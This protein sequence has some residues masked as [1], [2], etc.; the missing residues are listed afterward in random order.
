MERLSW[1]SQ[2]KRVRN[3]G[4]PRALVFGLILC[5]GVVPGFAAKFSVTLDRDTVVLGETVTVAFKFEGVQA[6][7]MPQLPAI[8]GLQPLGG[9]SSSSSHTQ[10]PDG[11][12]ESVQTFSVQMQATREGEIQIPS[13]TV[14]AANQKLVSPPVTLRVLREDPT[15]PPV[16]HA[17]QSA[18]L[19][20]VL[21]RQ[22]YF[23]GEVFTAELR[24]YVGQGVRNI[25]GYQP[26]Q[27]QGEGFSAGPWRQAQNYQRRVGDRVF[28]VVPIVCRI[29]PAKTGPL[30]IGAMNTTVV[31]NPPDAFE[32]F[33]GRRSNAERVALTLAEQEF[34]ILPLP[35]ENKPANFTGAVGNF[36]M[37][38]NVGPTNVATGDP[39]TVRVQISGRGALDGLTLPPQ[40]TWGEFKMYPPTAKVESADPFG[41]QGVKTFEQII[42][43]ESTDIQEL[44]PFT[45]SYFDPETKTYRTLTH[46][47]TRLVV[48]PGGAAVVPSVAANLNPNATDAAAPPVDIV[49]IK[50]RLGATSTSTAPL[51]TQPVFLVAQSVPVLAWLAAF[52]WRK[53]ADSLANNPRLRRQRQVEHTLRAG[54][55]KLRQHAAQNQS[56]EFFVGVMRLLQERLGERLDCPATAITEA[57]IDDRLR[58]RGVPDS[59]LD[60]LHQLFQWCNQARYAPVRTAQE[61]NAVL[62]KLESALR[63][64]A[65]VRV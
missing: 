6:R 50:Q 45:F 11:Q 18:F 2:F 36:T 56:D 54:L 13:F 14:E 16:S 27:L 33:F 7:G 4:F 42:S 64:L 35:E 61:L 55:E 58:P 40:N 30:K 59:T 12:M 48:R 26:P 31:L 24:L 37:S 19:W 57:V 9:T 63:K 25:D 23:L 41:L 20:L 3:A 65:E 22:E 34:R 1:Q 47:A 15:A 10:R 32:G 53:R 60:D 8:P 28:T 51:L 46:P 5:A 52:V 49:P 29:F 43:P 38:V 39:I 21:P 17:N 44:P 62:A